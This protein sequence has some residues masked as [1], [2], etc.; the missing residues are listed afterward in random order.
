M[1]VRENTL[2]IVT[3]RKGNPPEPCWGLVAKRFESGN[4]NVRIGKKEIIIVF[5]DQIIPIIHTNGF[6]KDPNRAVKRLGEQI[7]IGVILKL[8]VQ[9]ETEEL[10]DLIRKGTLVIVLS[11]ENKPPC[12]GIVSQKM[13][14]GKYDVITKPGFGFGKLGRVG[15]KKVFAEPGQLIP[16]IQ[17]DGSTLNPRTVL[18]RNVAKILMLIIV[19]LSATEGM[20][21]VKRLFSALSQVEGNGEL[22]L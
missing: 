17:T 12:W 18:R 3:S 20:K 5:P 7:I 1:E 13:P 11:P 8:F 16:V 6:V 2:V 15:R 22:L 14:S 21:S 4:F 9:K 19:K 10:V